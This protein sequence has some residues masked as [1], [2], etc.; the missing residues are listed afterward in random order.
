MPFTFKTIL[1]PVDFTINT[2]L[3]INKAVELSDRNGTKIYLLHVTSAE[4]KSDSLLPGASEKMEQWKTSIE[5]A[6]SFISVEILLENKGQL[7]K[8]IELMAAKLD[9]DLVVIGKHSHPNWHPFFKHLAPGMLA[10]NLGRAVLTVRPGSMCNKIRTV[11]IPVSN[12]ISNHK[13][14]SIAALINKPGIRIHLVTFVKDRQNT[15]D[16]SVSSLLKLYQWLKTNFDCQVEYAVLPNISR[17]RTLLDYA[18]KIQADLL[19]VNDRKE[20]KMGWMN[21]HI[22]DM[23]PPKSRVQVLTV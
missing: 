7:R 19:L 9:V 5:E 20:T 22:A 1:V 17:A 14:N 2:D 23:L 11:L 12:N 10:E 13:M 8:T 15:E 16:F 18:E 6:M 3:A 4:E 21:H